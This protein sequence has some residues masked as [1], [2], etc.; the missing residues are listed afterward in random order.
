MSVFASAFALFAVV[1]GGLA[2]RRT[3]QVW[4]PMPSLGLTVGLLMTWFV[5]PLGGL[6]TIGLAVG[7]LIFA[8]RQA[9]RLLEG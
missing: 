9:Q 3:A 8:D 7:G 4:G 2:V 5:L 6:L 1:L